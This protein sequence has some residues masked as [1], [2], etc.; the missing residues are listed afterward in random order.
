[1]LGR[2]HGWGFNTI[3]CFSKAEARPANHRDNTTAP[4]LLASLCKRLHV[5]FAYIGTGCIFQYDQEHPVPGVCRETR[6][7]S[8]RIFKKLIK[9]VPQT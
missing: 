7:A 3:D 6:Y 8:L 1:M 5:H 9:Q 2:T 4:L